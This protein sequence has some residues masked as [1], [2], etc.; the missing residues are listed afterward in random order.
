LYHS[1]YSLFPLEVR[2]HRLVLHVL[3]T[4]PSIDHLQ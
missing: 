4:I 2:V 1:V 3:P